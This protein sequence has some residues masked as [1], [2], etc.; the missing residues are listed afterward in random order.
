MK[1]TKEKIKIMQ[2]FEDGE[3]TQLRL[4]NKW[5]LLCDAPIWNWEFHDYRIKPKEKVKLYKWAIYDSRRSKW[6]ESIDFLDE[7][8]MKYIYCHDRFIKFKR[9]SSFIEE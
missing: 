7:K 3:D 4:N 6:T 1:T 5:I 9:L 2:A 8:Q